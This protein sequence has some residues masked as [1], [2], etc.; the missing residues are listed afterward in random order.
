MH[1]WPRMHIWPQIVLGG[2]LVLCASPGRT[3]ET[4]NPDKFK[5]VTNI[6]EAV[7]QYP[8]PSWRT[9]V[10]LD[11]SEYYR[12]Q[13]GPSFIFE[14]IPKGESFEAW[15]QLYAVHGAYL[16]KVGDL[17]INKYANLNMNGFIQACGRQNIAIT[18]LDDSANALTIIL[19]CAA[20]PN[21]SAKLGYGPDKGEIALMTFRRQDN[22]FIKVYHEWRGQKFTAEN[23]ATWPVTPTVLNEMIR[24]FKD[25]RI[26]KSSRPIK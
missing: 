23:N 9:S 18:K 11:D 24:R 25:I 15:T 26:S 1:I 13:K 22:T 19:F 10:S 8:A 3:A 16:P 7:V 5:H 4:L 2:L 12:D 14:Q 17:T 6:F 20:S 21:G